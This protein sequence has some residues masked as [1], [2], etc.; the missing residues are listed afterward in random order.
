MP[1]ECVAAVPA[2]F[3]D[4][5]GTL[6]EEVGYCARAEDVRTFPGVPEALAQLKKVGFL[7]IIITNQSGIARGYFSVGDYLNVQTELLRQLGGDLIDAT[8]FC[9]DHPDQPS[10]CR[11]P[12]IG[13]LEDAARDFEIDFAR[14]WLIGDKAIDIE[15]GQNAGLRTI[16]VETGYGK[17]ASCVPDFRAKTL[18]EA[19]AWIVGSLK[20]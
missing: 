16:L 3:L 5:D 4:R 12:A 11:K 10:R 2:V 7:N 1:V 9:A 19:V 14:S 15:C 18:S 17:Q 8:Y 13:M 20:S 6:M